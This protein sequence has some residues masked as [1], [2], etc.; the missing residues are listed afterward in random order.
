MFVYQVRRCEE[1]WMQ[2]DH[3]LFETEMAAIRY[4]EVFG[5]L[6]LEQRTE[7]HKD[8]LIRV[9]ADPEQ[10]FPKPDLTKVVDDEGVTVSLSWVTGELPPEDSFK[11]AQSWMPDAQGAF[12]IEI[13]VW[14]SIDSPNTIS[15]VRTTS[16]DIL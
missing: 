11:A 4:C 1:Y 10:T 7:T 8:G 3:G 9:Y 12:S 5:E 2:R 13:F 16:I 14:E 6:M 15:P